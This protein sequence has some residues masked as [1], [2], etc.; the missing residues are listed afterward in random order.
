MELPLGGPALRHYT[1]S[2][3]RPHRQKLNHRPSRAQETIIESENEGLEFMGRVDEGV[4]EFFTKK[5]QDEESITVHEVAPASSAPCPP[6][7]KTLRRKLGD[8]FTLKKRRALKSE[9]SQEGRPKK[10]SI[11]DFIRPPAGVTGETAVQETP[12]AGVPPLRA[13]V[14]P[15]RRALRE[16]KSQSLI[17]LSASSA[18]TAN[19]RNATKKQ[20]EGQHSF[21][22][23]LHLMLQRIGVSKAQPEETQ[24]QE[25]EMKKAESEGTIIDSK[26][27]PPPTFT[28]PRTMSASSEPVLKPGPPPA[29][30]GRNTPENELSQIEEAETNTPTKPSPAAAPPATAARPL[31]A[32][33]PA[34]VATI[35]SSAPASK[36]P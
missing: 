34:S 18:G 10:A 21:E 6:P 7:T 14:A 28:K 19:S 29:T 17:L 23:K 11:A 3:P 15:P 1:Q 27:E 22:Q 16:G 12:A 4:E 35:S 8:F 20:L 5:K 36:A 26:P 30:S 33:A 13:E 2:R 25:G 9:P 24:N 31:T 32:T